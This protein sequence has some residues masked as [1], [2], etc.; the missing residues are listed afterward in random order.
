MS[1]FKTKRKLKQRNFCWFSNKKSAKTLFQ[2]FPLLGNKI[3]LHIKKT[4]IKDPRLQPSILGGGRQ[5]FSNPLYSFILERSNDLI[6]SY[7]SYQNFIII[8]FVTKNLLNDAHILKV[9]YLLL[10][11]SPLPFTKNQ[12]GITPIRN[13]MN[14]TQYI[15]TWAFFKIIIPN[16]FSIFTLFLAILYPKSIQP[17]FYL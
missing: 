14:F 3:Y 17:S 11:H 2:L 15:L 7:L 9:Y 10:K 13:I 5:S 8:S 12:N 4:I 16:S 6:N 1:E